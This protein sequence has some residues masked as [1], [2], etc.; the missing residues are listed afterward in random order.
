ML[1]KMNAFD[2]GKEIIH[3]S[4]KIKLKKFREIQ[5]PKGIIR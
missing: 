3:Q 1:F 5:F 4:Q 2:S